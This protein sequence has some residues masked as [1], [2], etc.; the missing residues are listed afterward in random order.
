MTRAPFFDGK[1]PLELLTVVTFEDEGEATRVT[2]T[3]TP[4]NATEIERKTFADNMGSMNQGWSG[5]FDVL[6]EFL[7]EG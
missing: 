4:L 2:L 1:W 3:W 5:S 7:A 6:D